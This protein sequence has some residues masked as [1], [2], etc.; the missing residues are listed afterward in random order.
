MLIAGQPLIAAPP[1][2]PSSGPQGVKLARSGRVP[3]L[4]EGVVL[5]GAIGTIEFDETDAVWLFR[6]RVSEAGLGRA[7]VIL[8]GEVRAD[9]SEAIG[10]GS[11]ADES[12]ASAPEYEVFGRVY[13]HR[14]RNYL[15]A[16]GV[17]RLETPTIREPETKP[18]AETAAAP[19]NPAA[20]DPFGDAFLDEGD[21]LA[22]RLESE[23]EAQVGRA[24]RSVAVERS[25]AAAVEVRERRIHRRR[26]HLR[27]DVVTGTLLFVPEADGTG[28]RDPQYELLPCLELQRLEAF[29]ARPEA[30]RIIRLSGL[31]IE[32]GSRRFLLPSAFSSPR[33]GRGIGP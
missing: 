13:A 31:V 26:G 22:A 17:N 4:P 15:L 8:P 5:Q 20:A 30:P 11:D 12:A 33:E 6:P 2:A 18:S 3:L 29:A 16:S 1:P 14:G 25:D 9:I 19:A 10:I 27:R 7:L 28:T 21:D 32:E 24:P 23:L